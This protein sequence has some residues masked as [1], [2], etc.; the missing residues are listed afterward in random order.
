MGHKGVSRVHLS[1]A[2][3]KAVEREI[4]KQFKGSR[5]E[6]EKFR[7]LCGSKV[8]PRQRKR[9]ERFFKLRDKGANIISPVYNHAQRKLL[10]MVQKEWRANR[11]ARVIICKPRQTG[12]STVVQHLLADETMQRSY[13]RAAVIAHKREISAKVMSMYQVVL[14]HLPYKIPTASSSRDRVTFDEPLHSSIDIDSAE[15]DD[16][17]HGD[18]VQLLHCTE[19]SRWKDAERKMKGL[20][21]TVPDLPGTLVVIESTANGAS[22]YF[23]DLWQAATRG[24]S[25]FLPL[26]VA[27]FEHEEYT[28]Q[29]LSATQRQHLKDTLT[30]D[31]EALLKTLY[32][33]RKVGPT[34][35]TYEQL[36]WRRRVLTDK[37]NGDL[38]VFHEQY[39]ATPEEAFL[40]SGRPVFDP[41]TLD[42]IRRNAVPIIFRGDIEDL[43]FKHSSEPSPMNLEEAIRAPRQDVTIEYQKDEIVPEGLQEPVRAAVVVEHEPSPFTPDDMHD[44]GDQGG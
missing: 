3:R 29:R 9:M 18:T 8:E 38:D 6:Y 16:P 35:V 43:D 40:A 10:G 23:F 36:A 21:N 26:F 20:L 22:G 33:K 11:P 39:P 25:G 7:A 34:H 19:V 28:E 31:E 13:R 1:E 17:G 37:C 12:F 2:Q 41:V 5:A 30:A 24:D 42:E 27:W 4:D 44:E 15:S 32:F 14:R